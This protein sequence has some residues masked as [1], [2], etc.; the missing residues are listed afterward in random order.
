M[1]IL[2]LSVYSCI[3]FLHI[4]L[5]F[6]NHRDHFLSN[7]IFF[8]YIQE[9]IIHFY[10]NNAFDIINPVLVIS[11]IPSYLASQSFCKAQEQTI[12][13]EMIYLLKN[14]LLIINSI[15]QGDI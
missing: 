11:Y 12:D 10:D 5:E 2:N 15:I 9:N 8:I 1:Y 14:T 4:L 7:K 3:A 13:L 6:N